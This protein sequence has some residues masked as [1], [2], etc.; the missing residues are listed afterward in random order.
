MRIV[1]LDILRL[2]DQS[3]GRVTLGACVDRRNFWLGHVHVLAVA[4]LTAD[5]FGDMTICAKLSG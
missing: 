4:H 3:R 2:F 1:R 5:A